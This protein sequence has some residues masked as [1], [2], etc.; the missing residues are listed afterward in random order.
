MRSVL[1]GKMM[2]TTIHAFSQEEIMAYLDGELSPER[3]VAA[4]Q[5]LEQCR[6]C[7]HLAADFQNVS[8]KLVHWE[9]EPI[10]SGVPQ[11]ATEETQEAEAGF[12]DSAGTV[13][14]DC[15][16][17]VLVVAMPALLFVGPVVKGIEAGRSHRRICDT[18]GEGT[19]DGK[20]ENDGSWNV[21]GL[22]DKSSPAHRLCQ[23]A[24]HS[25]RVHLLFEPLSSASRARISTE[26]GP[27]SSASL[28]PIKAISLDSNSIRHRRWPIVER[29]ASTRSATRCDASGAKGPGARR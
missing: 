19:D 25:L 15:G 20:Q 1:R 4:A 16:G 7:Q 27:S 17:P 3:A 2:P 14:C 12:L 24:I 10:T 29:Y 21:N 8:Q 26:A 11:L 22:P 9:I 5:H 6:E 13:D 23:V 18:T 28:G